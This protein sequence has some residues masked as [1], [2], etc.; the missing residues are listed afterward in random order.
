M[1]KPNIQ[2]KAGGIKC[3]H[4]SYK[5][6]SVKPEDYESYINKPCPMCGA[7][8]LTYDDYK[9]FKKM[10]GVINFINKIPIPSFMKKDREEWFEADF[11]KKLTIKRSEDEQG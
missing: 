10:M 11:H 9:R 4:C 7:N 5:D 3:D 6:P 8:L 1:S 2:V